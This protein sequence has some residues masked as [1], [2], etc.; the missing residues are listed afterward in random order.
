MLKK[1][2]KAHFS[3]PWHHKRVP[4]SACVCVWL[5]VWLCKVL[6]LAPCLYEDQPVLII[7]K[8]ATWQNMHA[9]AIAAGHRTE[10]AA[11]GDPA[12]WFLEWNRLLLQQNCAEAAEPQHLK[13]QKIRL[14]RNR[15]MHDQAQVGQLLNYQDFLSKAVIVSRKKNLLSTKYHISSWRCSKY[16]KKDVVYQNVP[17]VPRNLPY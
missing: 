14:W 11:R 12:R 13:K 16:M 6:C 2:I 9:T 15:L 3:Q 5:Y 4:N 8:W 7:V 1:L 10:L 17:N